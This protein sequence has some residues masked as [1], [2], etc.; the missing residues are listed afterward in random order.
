MEPI[1]ARGRGEWVLDMSVTDENGA[2]VSTSTCTY[3][4]LPMPT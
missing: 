3:Y 4:L 1:E 2:T